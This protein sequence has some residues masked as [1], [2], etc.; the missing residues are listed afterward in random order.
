MTDE[1]R[2]PDEDPL[3]QVVSVFAANGFPR[4]PASVL[5]AIMAS[6]NGFV[7]AEQLAT[8]IGVSP[9]AISGAVRYLETVGM[10][11]RHRMPGSR[12]FV[13]E[14]PEYAWYTASLFKN[15]LYAAIARLAESSAGS[16]GPNGAARM[17]EMADFFIFLQQQLPQLLE[18][19]DD[20]RRAESAS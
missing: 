6:E 2:G 11:H 19:W 15:D 5:V 20:R 4:I 13:Y 3:A 10:I 1:A 14:L 8:R 12:R 17:R 9:A 18:Q 16:L 7:T